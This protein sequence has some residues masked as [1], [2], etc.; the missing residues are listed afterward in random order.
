[1]VPF[2]VKP[3]QIKQQMKSDLFELDLGQ[4]HP[5]FNIEHKWD[6]FF[7]KVISNEQVYVVISLRELSTGVSAWQEADC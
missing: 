2:Q 4:L 1:M 5:L 7:F 3:H 6:G